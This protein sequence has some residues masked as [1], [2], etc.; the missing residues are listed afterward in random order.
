MYFT[1]RDID[2][3]LENLDGLRERVFPKLHGEDALDG[4]PPIFSACQK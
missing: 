2:R 4:N 1:E 3:I